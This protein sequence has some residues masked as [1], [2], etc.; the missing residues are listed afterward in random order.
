[1]KLTKELRGLGKEELRSRKNELYTEILKMRTQ[2]AA[3][4]NP[5]GAGKLKLAKKN[6][7]RI[8]TLVHESELKAEDI[9]V[10]NK[11]SSTKSKPE[12]KSK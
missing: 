6:I 8:N 2:A 9:K 7:A 1:M 4:T 3:G 11:S 12:V 10:K 5:A